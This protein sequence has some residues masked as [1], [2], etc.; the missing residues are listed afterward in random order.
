MA[1]AKPAK[2]TSAGSGQ[3]RL[4]GG[5]WRG[6][7]LPVLDSEGLRPTTDRVKET[8]FNWLMFDVRGGRCLDLF[9][10]SGSLGFEALSR[11]AAEVVLVEKDARVAQQLQRNLASLP[12]ASGRVVNTDALGFLQGTATPF[13]LVFLD[14]PFHREL[15]PAACQQLEQGGWLSEDAKIYIEREQNA[16]TL[17][18]PPT[19]RL[20]KD[21]QAGQVSYQLYTRTQVE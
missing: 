7:K 4:I 18:L 14:P 3:I 8:L 19:W 1:K 15:L 12:A 17:P 2:K 13:D 20:L 16:E 9:A 21:K 6:R 11:G 10:G 5:Q